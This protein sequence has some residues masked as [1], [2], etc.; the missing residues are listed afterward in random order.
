MLLLD[1]RLWAS[2][3]PRDHSECYWHLWGEA[4]NA[5]RCPQSTARKTK[6]DPAPNA[7]CAKAGLRKVRKPDV[8]NHV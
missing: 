1:S 8:G 2:H 5:A 6:N 7:G 3:P 4:R